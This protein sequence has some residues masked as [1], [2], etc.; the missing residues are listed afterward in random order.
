VVGMLDV[1]APIS[2]QR[3]VNSTASF[4]SVAPAMGLPQMVLTVPHI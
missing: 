2:S 3:L 1:V 4:N